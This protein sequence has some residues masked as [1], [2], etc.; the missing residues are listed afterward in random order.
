MLSRSFIATDNI[1]LT[2]RLKEVTYIFDLNICASHRQPFQF[3]KIFSNII[4][5]PINI[6]YNLEYAYLHHK[7]YMSTFNLQISNFIRLGT[8]LFASL[9]GKV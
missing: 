5:T 4:S 1:C 6:D 3:N 7:I 2:V 8:S 9:Y